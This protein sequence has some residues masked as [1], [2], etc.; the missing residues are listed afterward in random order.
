MK[1][2]YDAKVAAE[3]SGS[4]H[5]EEEE[6]T[7]E[8]ESTQESM[9]VVNRDDGSSD[10]WDGLDLCKRIDFAMTGLDLCLTAKE[11]EQELRRAFF[12]E[13]SEEDLKKTVI[14]NAK[15]L[16]EKDGDFAKFAVRR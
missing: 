15:S 11:I 7:L 16:I 5:E 12:N 4:A 10:L 14:L 2:S 1:R 9:I 6:Q 3:A 13:M 8:L